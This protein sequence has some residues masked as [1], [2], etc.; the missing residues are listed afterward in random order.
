MM[1]FLLF[2]LKPKNEL[3]RLMY[4]FLVFYPVFF[5][6]TACSLSSTTHQKPIFV[7]PTDLQN[8][9]LGHN[10]VRENLGL[11]PF[12]WSDKMVRYAQ[13]WANHQATTKNCKMQHR[14]HHEGK[15]KQVYGENL[16]WA[17]PKRWSDGKVERQR[18]TILEVI[19]AWTDEVVDYDYQHNSCTAGEQCGH[20]TQIVWRE[21]RAV[22][23]AIALCPDQSQ[24][25]VCNYDPPGNYIGERPY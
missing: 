1:G 6:I 8:A 20:Y 25:W 10:I 23:C 15:F 3:M 11:N 14:P 13:E 21:T 24:L 12:H 22:G 4:K 18:I 19:K 2:I 7:E 17:S 5:L 9:L 16:F